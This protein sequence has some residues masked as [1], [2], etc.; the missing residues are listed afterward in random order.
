MNWNFF[1]CRLNNYVMENRN[2]LR[3]NDTIR[4]QKLLKQ[5]RLAIVSF[6]SELPRT[7]HMVNTFTMD[8]ALVTVS[9]IIF[10]NSSGVLI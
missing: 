9:Y 5:G 3:L 7:R 6:I 2:L 4:R 8:I 10:L 1:C